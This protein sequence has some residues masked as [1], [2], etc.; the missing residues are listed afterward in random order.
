VKAIL[1]VGHDGTFAS[2]GTMAGDAADVWQGK[3]C[4]VA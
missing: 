2:D 3:P 4:P 1:T